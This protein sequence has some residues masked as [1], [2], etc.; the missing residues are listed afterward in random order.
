MNH[1]DTQLI[2]TL[3]TLISDEIDKRTKV[4]EEDETQFSIWDHKSDIEDMISEFINS[5][6]TITLE[7]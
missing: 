4:I 6:V 7:T 5:N 1:F 3:R 2:L